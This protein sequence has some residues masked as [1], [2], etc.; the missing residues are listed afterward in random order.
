MVASLELSIFCWIMDTRLIEIHYISPYTHLSFKRA[1]SL[2]RQVNPK[3]LHTNCINTEIPVDCFPV[4]TGIEE[5]LGVK[6]SHPLG[7]AHF[8]Q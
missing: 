2:T 5:D 1:F 7:E 4:M 8:V 6:S 3:L